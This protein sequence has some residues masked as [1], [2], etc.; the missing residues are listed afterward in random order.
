MEDLNKAMHFLN[1]GAKAGLP[2]KDIADLLGV[3]RRTLRRWQLDI[4]G[5]GLSGNR[6][7]GSRRKVAHKVTAEERKN[8]VDTINNSRIADLLPREIV[9]ILAEEQ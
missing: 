7:K 5:Q 8:E 1:E 6:R 3:C 2:I 4:N 9:V